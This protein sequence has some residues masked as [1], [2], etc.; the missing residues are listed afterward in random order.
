MALKPL[1]QDQN[2]RNNSL[3]SKSNKTTKYPE[4]QNH[5][6]K[7]SL[8]QELL[9]VSFCSEPFTLIKW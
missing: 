5:H 6:C 9:A 4:N 2:V 7:T 3:L 8:V 1:S